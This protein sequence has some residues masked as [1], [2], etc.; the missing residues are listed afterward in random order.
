MNDFPDDRT[1]KKFGA[2]DTWGPDKAIIIDGL[3]GLS[4]AAMSMVVGGKPIRSQQEW[5]MAQ[6][7]LEGF[8]RMVC[9]QCRCWFVLIGHVE[10]EPDEVTGGVKLMPSTLG[11]KLAPKI[12]PMFSDVIKTVREGTTWTWDTAASDTDVKARN[13]PWKAGQAQDFKPLYQTWKAKADAY[14]K[15]QPDT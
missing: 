14:A 1:G 8:L 2:V 3:T 6:D 13:L 5:G 10:R 15:E 12:S 11:K 7:Q 9:D 4:I